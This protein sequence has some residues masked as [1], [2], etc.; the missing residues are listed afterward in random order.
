MACSFQLYTSIDEVPLNIW[1]QLVPASNVLMHYDYLHRLEE[2]EKSQLDFR[3]VLISQN[4]IPVG[5]VYFQV[6]PFKGNDLVHFIPTGGDT[7]W[8][9]LLNRLTGALVVPVLK[10]ID[11]KLLV[12]G[13]IFMTG[14]S[15]FYFHPDTDKVTRAIFLRKA[16][17][18]VTRKDSRIKAVLISDLVQPHTDFD[19]DFSTCSFHEIK[20]EADMSMN[21]REE[22]KTLDDYLKALSSKYRV[23]ARK[24]YKMNEEQEIVRRELGLGEIE[25]Y[26]DSLY[27]LYHQ[28]MDNSRFKLV[29]LSKDFF[30]LQKKQFPEQYHIYGY[31]CGGELIGFISA[32]TFFRKMDI[33]YCGME[34]GTSRPVHLYQRML[35][36]MVEL[37]IR[38]RM[39]QLHF[40]RTAPEIK[41]TIGAVPLNTYGYIKHLNPF[42]NLLLTP[43]LT[44]LLQPKEYIYRNPFKG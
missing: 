6:A 16:A 26:S 36:D 28:V 25:I 40:G 5:A 38:L 35:Y 44:R 22:W 23:R 42:F 21:L 43:L 34:G 41:S 14:E 10:G 32:Y 13:N 20:A 11:V 29:T 8:R 12:S 19:T 24:V 30:H 2:S 3:Y 1:N 27:R 4:E 31:F 9:K 18:E 17:E 37:G 7:F 39:R 15:G 33:H